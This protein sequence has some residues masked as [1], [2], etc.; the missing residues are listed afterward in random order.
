MRKLQK[1]GFTIVEVLV[2]VTVTSILLMVIMN[3]MA[4][5]LVN[6]AVIQARRDLLIQAQESLD[7]IADETRV[8]ANADLNNRWS[9]ENAPGAP[10]N[11]LSWES[12][13]DTLILATAAQDS[14][15]N[16]IFADSANYIT[17]KN[18]NVYFVSGGSLYRR[19]LASPVDGNSTKTTCPAS[20]A[21][22]TC[23]ADAELI[24][25]VTSFSV[26]YLDG[27]DNKVEPTSA[28]SIRMNIALSRSYYGR[29]ITADYTTRM[30]FRND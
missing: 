20:A 4:D 8:S 12:D 28:R 19:R 7:K 25:N 14:D 18:N 6:Y 16:I 30:V 9:D 11:L 29:T 21:S 13:S 24:D 23:P 5:A 10:D 26:D 15:K 22:A 1:K 3:F 2:A 27:N 17:E